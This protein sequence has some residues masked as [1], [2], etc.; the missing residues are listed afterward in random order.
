MPRGR[1]GSRPCTRRVLALR[2]GTLVWPMARAATRESCTDDLS[3]QAV[4]P[5]NRAAALRSFAGRIQVQ[6]NTLPA[7]RQ[8][9]GSRNAPSF[10]RQPAPVRRLTQSSGTLQTAVTTR[11]PERT[12]GRSGAVGAA[13]VA[14]SSAALPAPTCA[15]RWHVG[16]TPARTLLE[17]G[18][19]CDGP[20]TLPRWSRAV[21]SLPRKCGRTRGARQMRWRCPPRT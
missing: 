21:T 9:I 6:R 4:N 7:T 12:E 8:D 5:S 19:T 18:V 20:S 15:A 1:A 2:R 14:A 3:R 11:H 10:S 17:R 13:R 16:T